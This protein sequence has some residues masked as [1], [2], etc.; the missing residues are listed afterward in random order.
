[1]AARRSRR[2]GG[3]GE[4]RRRRS[5][6]DWARRS[7]RLASRR[8]GKANGGV[9]AGGEAAVRRVDGGLSSPAFGVERRRHSVLWE[10]GNGKRTRGEAFWGTCSAAAR[11]ESRAG[12]LQRALHG[13]VAVAAAWVALEAAG[14]RGTVGEHQREQGGRWVGSGATRGCQR[15][16]KAKLELAGEAAGGAARFGGAGSRAGRLGKKTGT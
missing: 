13:G 11:E 10:W 8:R 9:G 6:E 15:E 14:V 12:A 7:G 4:R 1:M 5:G 16:A 2:V 3:G